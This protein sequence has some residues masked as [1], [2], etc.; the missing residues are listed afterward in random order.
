[1]VMTSVRGT[2]G[3]PFAPCGR[4][5]LRWGGAADIPLELQPGAVASIVL[6]AFAQ[7]RWRCGVRLRSDALAVGEVEQAEGLVVGP[8]VLAVNPHH[9][10]CCP[11]NV[12]DHVD[13]DVEAL[14]T[15]E[16]TPVAL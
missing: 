2:L 8:S 14:Y 7:G 10:G 3:R 13:I 12:V 15:I 16:F 9:T 1:M 6:V 11:E 4:P 5:V